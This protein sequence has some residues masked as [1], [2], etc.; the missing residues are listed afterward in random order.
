M[1]VYTYQRTNNTPQVKD[2]PEIRDETPLGALLW[3]GHHNGTLCSPQE[4][5]T[6][7]EQGTGEDQESAVLSVRVTEQT[8][9][10]DTVTQSTK[11]QCKFDT[12][13]VDKGSGEESNNC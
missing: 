7:T 8:G 12:Q 1:W 3:V 10:V 2:H 9:R 13:L 11:R 6:D 4:T 5:G